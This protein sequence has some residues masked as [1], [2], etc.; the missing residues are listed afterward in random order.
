MYT[1]SPDFALQN[2]CEIAKKSHNVY[3]CNKKFHGCS[4]SF[5]IV[6]TRVTYHVAQHVH[7]VTPTFRSTV[8]NTFMIKVKSQNPQE[9]LSTCIR[10]PIATY[11][12]VVWLSPGVI[13]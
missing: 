10:G 13:P 3:S 6:G 11:Q 5:V 4:I 7:L 2:F 12:K 1:M 8:K 9:Y